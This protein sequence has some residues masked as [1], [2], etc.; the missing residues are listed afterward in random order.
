MKKKAKKWIVSAGVCLLAL[1]GMNVSF[2]Q[3]PIAPIPEQF[4]L[5]RYLITS[6]AF[7]NMV[8]S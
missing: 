6:L 7:L 4:S 3:G 1:T 8:F 2:G 5:S